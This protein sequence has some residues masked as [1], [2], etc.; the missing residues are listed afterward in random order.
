MSVRSR[1]AGT[2]SN[3]P[4]S[5]TSQTVPMP[6]S[7]RLSVDAMLLAVGLLL[8]GYGTNVSTPFLVS[9]RDRLDLGDSATMAIFAVYVVGIFSSLLVAGPVSDRYGRRTVC[10]PFLAVSGL[11][12]LV[13]ILGRDSFVLLLLGRFLLG[14]VSGAVF[15]VAA[16]WMQELLGRGQEQRAAVITTVVTYLGFGLGPP[17]SAVFDELGAAPLVLPFVLHAILSFAFVPLLARVPETVDRST[18]RRPIRVQLGVPAA[19]RRPFLF[20]IVPAAIWVF[21]FPS[22][23]FALFPVII[24]ENISGSDVTVAAAS[25]ALTAWSALIARPLIVR[26]G[27]RRALPIAMAMGTVGYALGTVA[28]SSGTWPFVLPA[29]VLLGA[30]SGALTAATLGLLG[31]MADPST[32]GALS[33]TVFLLAYPGMAMPLLLTTVAGDSGMTEA[34]LGV[35]ILAVAGTAIAIVGWQRD[36]SRPSPESR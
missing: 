21:S 1:R 16:A 28:F 18:N 34:L 26:V 9:Y 23:S 32:R 36:L 24:S 12:S 33:S 6:P 14:A 13:L 30:A 11:A 22:T 15:G 2:R 7:T 25:G 35:T 20:V 29:A 27:A 31:E 3:T 5:T 17:V 10:V 8:V 4:S 19:A